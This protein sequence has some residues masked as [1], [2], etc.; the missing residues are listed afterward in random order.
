MHP[1]RVLL[2]CLV[3]CDLLALLRADSAGT[4]RRSADAPQNIR[5]ECA[6]FSLQFFTDQFLLQIFLSRIL[7]KPLIER[8]LL[9]L[10]FQ[11]LN[12]DPLLDWLG[13]TL[14]S[15]LTDD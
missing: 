11:L 5:R 15:H 13:F 12:E 7:V 9:N 8:L 10:L 6:L 14:V 3:D 1:V 4:G 2:V